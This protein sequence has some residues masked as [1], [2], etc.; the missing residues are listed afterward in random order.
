MMGVYMM[1]GWASCCTSCWNDCIYFS[2]IRV[3]IH[4]LTLRLL[5]ILLQ[6][7]DLVLG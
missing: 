4:C 2:F 7:S 6:L 5:V 1:M 3:H